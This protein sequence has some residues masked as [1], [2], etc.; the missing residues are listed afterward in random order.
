MYYNTS[1]CTNSH[2]YCHAYTR[3]KIYS[4]SNFQ[5]R[6]Q[7]M[8]KTS[9]CTLF[10]YCKCL[11]KKQ[12]MYSTNNKK[13]HNSDNNTQTKWHII[14]PFFKTHYYKTP[15]FFGFFT[16][17]WWWYMVVGGGGDDTNMNEEWSIFQHYIVLCLH[18]GKDKTQTKWKCSLQ[19]I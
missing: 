7:V 13:H 8:I 5:K 11:K 18:I 16:M 19:S 3:R 14:L 17:K 4:T 15:L 9:S 10:V 2:I 12:S 1:F 6:F